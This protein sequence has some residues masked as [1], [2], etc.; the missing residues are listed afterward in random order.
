MNLHEELSEAL[1]KKDGFEM[2]RI[3]KEA[4]AAGVLREDALKM[5][6]RLFEKASCENDE[7]AQALIVDFMDTL[8][9]CCQ[10]RHCIWPHPPGNSN[11][12][13]PRIDDGSDES[14]L[15]Q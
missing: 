5:L 12:S 9:F 15:A 13:K 3:L 10:P 8:K 2:E 7:I 4:Q 6:E 14:G 11:K 1:I